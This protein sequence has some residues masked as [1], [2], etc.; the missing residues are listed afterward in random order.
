MELNEGLKDKISETNVKDHCIFTCIH[1]HF[2]YIEK[3][4][5]DYYTESIHINMKLIRQKKH[6]S[7]TIHWH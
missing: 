7:S 5:E 4:E 3:H 1:I 2:L 6:S